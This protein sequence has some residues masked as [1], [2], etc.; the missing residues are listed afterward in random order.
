[1]Q[2]SFALARSSR[3]AR[4]LAV[5]LLAGVVAVGVGC[6]SSGANGGGDDSSESPDDPA[7]TVPAAP[8][9]LT[10]TSGDGQVVLDWSSVS[11]AEGYNV[12]RS[13]ASG[14]VMEGDPL[15]GG[16]S[17]TRYTDGGAQNGTEYHYVVTAVKGEAESRPTD[18][19]SRT[20][21]SSPPD[22]RP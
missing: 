9:G 20:P 21:F 1:M 6:G 12:Y 16:V 2:M 5:V 8:S 7:P 14:S 13:T 17:S 15:M 22:E 19:I 11:G 3:L 10:A 18:A 4:G